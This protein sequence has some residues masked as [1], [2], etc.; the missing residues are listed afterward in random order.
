V[1]GGD[2]VVHSTPAGKFAGATVAQAASITAGTTATVTAGQASAAARGAFAG[3]I[4]RYGDPLLIVDATAAAGKLAWSVEVE[5]TTPEGEPSR[6][7]V[8]VDA[9]TGTVLSNSEHVRSA[10]G[11]G[12]GLYSGKVSIDTAP[13]GSS[14]TLTDPV[15]GN[16][17]TCDGGNKDTKQCTDFTDPDNVWGNGS[18][19]DRQSAAVE[20]HYGAAQTYDYFKGL[21]RNG[22]FGDG[23][24]VP[25]IVHFGDNTE[26]AYWDGKQ[27]LYGDG[28]DNAK[29]VV[30]LDIAGHEMTHGV[31]ER[32]ANLI[33]S[34]EPGGLNEATSDIFGAMVEYAAN[35]AADPGDYDIGEKVD[36]LGNGKAFRFMHQPSLDGK[37]LDCWN[38]GA[39][40]LDVHFSSGIGNHFFYLLAEGS[41]GGPKASPT[42]GAPAVTGIG[43]EKAA[44]LYFRAL[45]TYFVSTTNY[46]KAREGTLSAAADLYGKCG[47]EH[48]AVNAAWAGAGVK[49]A[50]PC[51]A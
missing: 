8:I 43:R 34:G 14:F 29:P 11:T 40:G 47:T 10:T 27:M 7:T 36:L 32:T 30:S 37:S 9:G 6:L 22:I 24:G 41:S 46:A 21:G 13:A 4:H 31:T 33:Y 19:S 20:A 50:A 51:P 3:A 45:T 17:R 2:F 18:A 12:N 44:R 26:N 16:G 39:G 48:K 23:K 15:R 35:N 28:A 1:R 49:G 42:C 25:S 5:G 38:S